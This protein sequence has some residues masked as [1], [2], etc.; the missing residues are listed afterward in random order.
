MKFHLSTANHTTQTE[1]ID[2]GVL[3]TITL[4]RLS[5]RDFKSV[6][7]RKELCFAQVDHRVMEMEHL[8]SKEG[9][10]GLGWNVA[11]AFAG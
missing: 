7:S 4:T 2:S 9:Q 11:S 10:K 3:S 6:M 5:G 1:K 8:R